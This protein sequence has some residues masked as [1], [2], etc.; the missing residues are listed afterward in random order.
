[1][2]N[3]SAGHCA[4]EAEEEEGADL[5]GVQVVHDF[6]AGSSVYAPGGQDVHSDAASAALAFPVGHCSQSDGFEEPVL[7]L[8]APGPQGLQVEALEAPND[9]LDVPTGHAS[10]ESDPVARLYLPP[11]HSVQCAAPAT[12]AYDPA[13][14]AVQSLTASWRLA[15]VPSSKR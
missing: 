11:T 9:A 4:Q 7:G 13:G 8:K 2:L 3:S 6:V 12:L 15:S 5:P 1:M 14:H 10:Q